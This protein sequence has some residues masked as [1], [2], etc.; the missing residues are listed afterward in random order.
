MMV[1]TLQGFSFRLLI[2]VLAAFRA[3]FFGPSNPAEIGIS[4]CAVWVPGGMEI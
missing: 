3:G 2:Q 1:V 4:A